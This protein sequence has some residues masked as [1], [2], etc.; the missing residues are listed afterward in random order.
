MSLGDNVVIDISD[1][2]NKYSI[3]N[4]DEGVIIDIKN[5]IYTI[6]LSNGKKN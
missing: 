6:K 2:S 4:L 1:P 5:K 3:Y